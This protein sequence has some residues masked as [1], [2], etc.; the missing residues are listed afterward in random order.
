MLSNRKQINRYISMGAQTIDKKNHSESENLRDGFASKHLIFKTD[1]KW[2]ENLLN[3]KKTNFR[4]VVTPY[5]LFEPL[6]F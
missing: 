5:S 1:W 6:N 3:V 2:F 4:F